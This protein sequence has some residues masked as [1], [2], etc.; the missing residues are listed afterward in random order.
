MS[1]GR[2]NPLNTLQQQEIQKNVTRL[3]GV[4]AEQVFP[5]NETSAYV[6]FYSPQDREVALKRGP[7]EKVLTKPL[8]ISKYTPAS[9]EEKTDFVK[10]AAPDCLV[11]IENI[12]P[13]RFFRSNL[14]REL[15]PEDSE[16]SAAYRISAENAVFPSPTTALLRF[17]S[18]EQAESALASDFVASR[19]VEL[20]KYPAR[21]FRARRDIVYDH[22][23]GPAK[24]DEMWVLGP[25][26]IVDGDMPSKH[27]YLSHAGS[28]LLRGLD[29]ASMSKE[30]ITEFFQPFSITIRDARG[31]VEFVTCEAGLP[32]GQAYVGFDFLG[33]A[34]S[35]MKAFSGRAKIGNSV[36]K[37]KLIKDRW[38]PNARPR[39]QRPERSEEEILKNLNDWEQYVDPEDIKYLEEN[40]VPKH[41]LD[42][43]LRGIRYYNRSFGSLD[44]AMQDEKLEPEKESGDA[45]RELV[46]MYVSTLKECIATPEDPG[47]P[48]KGLHFP[49]EPLDMS[50]FEKE[51]KRQ[52]ELLKKRQGL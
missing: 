48:F 11:K 38:M 13:G 39:Q 49:G 25:K 12:P 52:E 37:M 7:K 32:T 35:A 36:V 3:L 20:G 1:H 26:L 23:G 29:V 50:V 27:F 41:V 33:Q 2:R 31:S 30:N 34:E 18:A 45:Y 14:A 21:L 4:T 19:L 51:K 24:Q 10:A 44:W 9:E 43:S 28:I 16:F 17:E 40:G 22:M 46:Q 15:F 5:A 42:E 8:T 47:E 6:G